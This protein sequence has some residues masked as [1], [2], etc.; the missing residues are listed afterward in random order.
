MKFIR[1]LYLA[2][3]LTISQSLCMAQTPSN[4]YFFHT[5]TK[6]QSLYS[7]SSMYN[8][9]AADIISLNPGSNES[10]RIGEKLRIP[11]SNHSQGKKRFH[12]IKKGETLYKITKEYNVSEYD[13]CNFNPGLSASNFKVGQ[14]IAIPDSKKGSLKQNKPSDSKIGTIQK[15]EQKYQTIHKVEKKETLYSICRLYGITEEEL[16]TANPELKNSKLKK[17]KFLRIPNHAIRSSV[18]SPSNRQIFAN[19][20]HESK[21]IQTIKT[22]VLL[23]FMTNENNSKEQAKMVEYYEG[24]LLA[25]DSLKKE[26]ISTDIYAF[27]T[28][29]NNNKIE[30]ILNKPELKDVN[31]IFGPAY[32]E[33][34]EAVSSFAKANKIKLVI[35]FTSKVEEVYNNPY[36]YQVNSPQSYIY[37]QVYDNFIKLFNNTN[38][39][40]IDTNDSKNNK[41]DFISGFKTELSSNGIKYTTIKGDNVTPEEI[42]TVINPLKNNIIIPISGSNITL[43]KLLPQLVIVKRENPT[44][45]IKLFGYPEWQTYTQDHLNNIHELDTYFYSTF[46]SNNLFESTAKFSALFRKSYSKMLAPT[47]PKY[48]ILG[49]DTG[50]QFLKALATYGT[51][52]DNNINNI[53]FRP[54]QNGFKFARVNN[55]GG[56]VNKKVFFIHYSD[57]N[58]LEKLDFN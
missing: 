22:A 10:I 56:F 42:Q 40:F 35:P 30:Q 37:S 34:I 9:T 11:Q 18:I 27:D 45:E 36:I 17:G 15:E 47:Y 50:Y 53:P 33:Q 46:Y 14:V 32:P 29:S 26:G 5:V 57:N 3:T 38:V 54:I 48:G 28:G 25:V 44:T 58:E 4:S 55:W 19:T 13:I 24:F 16:I 43:T 8:V 49:F 51:I 20:K 21:K 23:P 7:I 52:V 31:I 6:G 41:V 39:I 1:A 2:T 12:T